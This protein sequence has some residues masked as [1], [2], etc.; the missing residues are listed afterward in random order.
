MQNRRKTGF[1]FRRFNYAGVSDYLGSYD[2]AC[3]IFNIVYA[4]NFQTL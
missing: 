1:V 3:L 2:W 4:F